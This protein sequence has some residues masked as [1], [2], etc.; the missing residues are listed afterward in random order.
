MDTTFFWSEIMDTTEYFF[1]VLKLLFQFLLEVKKL[2]IF[3]SL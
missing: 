1:E 2:P 3:Q